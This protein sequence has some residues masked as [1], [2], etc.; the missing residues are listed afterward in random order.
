[1]RGDQPTGKQ[2]APGGGINK[3]RRAAAE[4]GVPVTVADLIADQRIAGWLIRN[5]QQGFGQTH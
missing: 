3:H 1:M 4:V 5:T 2:Q